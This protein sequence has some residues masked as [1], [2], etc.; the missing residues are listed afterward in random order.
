MST[1]DA[2]SVVFA[3]G[4]SISS[5]TGSFNITATESVT[6]QLLAQISPANVSIHRVDWIV[7]SGSDVVTVN[8]NGV[9]TAIG[10]GSAVIA[11]YATDGS[12]VYGEANVT[13]NDFSGIENVVTEKANG[14]LSI[15]RTDTEIEISGIEAD[16]THPAIIR[17][18]NTSGVLL[19]M[20]SS[21]G[22]S[23]RVNISGLPNGVYI[24]SSHSSQSLQSGRFIV[25]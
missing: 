25:R 22:R 8:E 24:V 14:K 11:A 17:I 12:G 7:I 18:Y 9:V 3:S 5:E 23:K 4:I 10:N 15:T 6:L 21:S 13:V 20:L 19:K 1:A 16:E 2:G